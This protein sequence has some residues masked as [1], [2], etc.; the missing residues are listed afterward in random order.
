MSMINT[1]RENG[2]TLEAKGWS[3]RVPLLFL[4]PAPSPQLPARKVS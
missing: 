3:Q 2:W 4:A 1:G